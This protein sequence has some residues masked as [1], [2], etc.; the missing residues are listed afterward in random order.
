[1]HEVNIKILLGQVLASGEMTAKQRNRLLAQMTDE[2][3]ELVLAH[4][5]AQTQS[6]SLVAWKSAEKLYEH[7]RFID[8][9]EQRG[10]LN[11]KLEYLPDAK[12]IAERQ[13]NQRGLTKPEIAVLHAYSKMNYYDAL[14]DSD[15]S[16][17]SYL[18]AEMAGYFPRVLVERFPDEI[19]AHRLL[20][21]ITATYLTNR[22]VD[23]MG[24]GFGF[25]VR[26]EVGANIDSLTRAFVSVCVIFDIDRIWSDIEGLD[27]MVS[28]SVQMEMMYAVTTLLRRTVTWLLRYRPND[29]EI[30]TV[31]GHF[32]RGVAELTEQMP[33]P[34]SAP[35]RLALN[36]QVKTLTQS[37]VE[38]ELARRVGV[39]LPL[40][41]ALDLVEIARD[42]G[43]EIL[44][45]AAV[46]YQLGKELDFHWL[47]AQIDKLHIHTHWHDLAR[48]RL[49]E[50][51]DNHQREIAAHVLRT[52]RS[53]KKAGK[54]IEQWRAANQA[55][56]QRHGEILAEF[57]ARSSVDFAML[58]MVVAGA[59]TLRTV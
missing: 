1:D 59:E 15:I 16:H 31:I 23:H 37:G 3:A 29:L 44:D 50:M 54:M 32:R 38:Q 11:R 48:T 27:N 57:K 10:K 58:S 6:I 53:Y 21:E 51:L 9:L 17:D 13:A 43:R 42:S 28:A 34:L 39:L 40:A 35:D 45:V 33:K 2:V 36:R 55:A 30:A 22:I 8:H 41:S 7:A 18:R 5:Y 19:S 49:R 25:R 14:I 26:E 24:P 20:R 4:N 56:F 52:T 47:H 46:Y 12:M